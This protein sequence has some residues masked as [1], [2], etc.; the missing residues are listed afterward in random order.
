MTKLIDVIFD[1]SVLKPC[2]PLYLKK[3]EHYTVQIEIESN[4]ESLGKNAWDVLEEMTGSIE[5]PGDWAKEH[6]HYLYGTSKGK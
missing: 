3:D 4:R 2:A 5:A 1:G 6:D